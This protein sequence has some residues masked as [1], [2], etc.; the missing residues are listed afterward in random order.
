MVGTYLIHN[1]EL[2]RNSDY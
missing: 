1:F 2:R